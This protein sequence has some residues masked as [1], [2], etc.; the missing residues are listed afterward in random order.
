MSP[1]NTFVVITLTLIF[2]HCLSVYPLTMSAQEST[3][4][5]KEKK[6]QQMNGK[7]GS[8]L[9]ARF[10]FSRSDELV[11]SVQSSCLLP[12]CMCLRFHL[13]CRAETKSLQTSMV[14]WRESYLMEPEGKSFG[15]IKIHQI[16]GKGSKPF[17]TCHKPLFQSEA[18]C[19]AIDMKTTFNSHANKTHF[20]K[21]GF[22]LSLV[23]I[24][25][26]FETC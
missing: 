4:L 11:I 16:G 3:R 7:N 23:L 26:V 15:A 2:P 9:L 20:H 17:L 5:L 18:K 14:S 1:I 25:R 24:M 6:M 13:R 8:H 12:G 10:F 19:E 21:K 22:A